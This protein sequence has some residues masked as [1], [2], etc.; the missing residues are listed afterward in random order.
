MTL[1]QDGVL[2]KEI[3]LSLCGEEIPAFFVSL[4]SRTKNRSLI[5]SAILLR[6]YG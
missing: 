2:V 6:C 5:T 3:F 1:L 4:H